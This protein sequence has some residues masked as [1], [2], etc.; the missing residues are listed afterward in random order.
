META[1]CLPA[2]AAGSIIRSQKDGSLYILTARHCLG[3]SVSSKYQ[4]GDPGDWEITFNYF[5]PDLAGSCRDHFEPYATRDYVIVSPPCS[6]LICPL[7]CF[8]SQ[9][10]LLGWRGGKGAML[11]LC[12]EAALLGCASLTRA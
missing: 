4:F 5:N 9:L 3:G 12:F 10:I 2:H 1:G 11:A 8:L 7:R 6:L